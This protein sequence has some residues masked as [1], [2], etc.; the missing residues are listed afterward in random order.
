MENTEL[1]S[2]GENVALANL[3]TKHICAGVFMG[4]S[5]PD[6][7]LQTSVDST[8]DPGLDGPRTGYSSAVP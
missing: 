5:S 8:L 3:P 7:L 2:V 4:A 6:T 1:H